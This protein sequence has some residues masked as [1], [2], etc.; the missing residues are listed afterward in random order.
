VKA[1][2]QCGLATVA[3]AALWFAA[4]PVRA[5]TTLYQSEQAVANFAFASQLGSGIYGVSGRTVQIY[6]LPFSWELAPAQADHWGLRLTLPV[7]LGFYDFRLADVLG[8]QLPDH[9]DTYSVV[10][11]VELS[12]LLG[13]RWRIAAFA[14]AGPAHEG[15][16]STSGF[17]YAG[18]LN[19]TRVSAPGKFRARYHVALLA[20]AADY[21]GRA[22]DSMLRLTNAVEARRNLGL[23][24]HGVDLDWGG[25]ALNEWYLVRP[26]PPLSAAGPGMA[27][28]QSE[29]G[30]TFG[31]AQPAHVWKIPVPRLG[32][33][34]RFGRNLSAWRIVLGAA[35]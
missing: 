8:S 5:A 27:P 32:L 1:N 30:V 24:V 17:V 19:A 4:H 22:H 29:F 31:T 15:S 3:V 2:R 9:I 6:R 7:T 28:F 14:E 20:A 26:S 18:G 11:G 34:Y 16:N 12:R 10:P 13:T 21:E 35:F 25:Y 23:A 33:G